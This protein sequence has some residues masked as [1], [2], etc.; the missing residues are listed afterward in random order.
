[1][2]FAP[3]HILLT[4]NADVSDESILRFAVTGFDSTDSSD[5]QYIDPNKVVELPELSILSDK[6][7]LM[8]EMIGDTGIPI[9][10]HEIGL[11]FSG[12]GQRRL[13]WESSS[14]S[15]ESSVSS[16]SSSSSSSSS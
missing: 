5:Y 12:D 7:K 2:G 8:V 10:L 9:V 3:K 16:Y 4:Y 1:M 13:N 14:S 6:F 11:M 15:S